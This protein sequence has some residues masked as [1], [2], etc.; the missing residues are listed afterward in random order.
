[1]SLILF[2]L[3]SKSEPKST[4]YVGFN[5]MGLF[6]IVLLA[7]VG[8]YSTSYEFGLFSGLNSKLILLAKVG[9]ILIT[10]WA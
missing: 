1:M 4:I 2:I 8:L 10:K 3:I 7:K 5:L 9:L 6:R